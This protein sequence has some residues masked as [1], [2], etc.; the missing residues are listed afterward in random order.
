MKI[1]DYVRVNSP[2]SKNH[3]KDGRVTKYQA[4][5][6][7][8]VKMR[9]NGSY[10]NIKRYHLIQHPLVLWMRKADGA[11]GTMPATNKFISS[12]GGQVVYPANINMFVPFFFKVGE[13]VRLMHNSVG[14]TGDVIEVSIQHSRVRVRFVSRSGGVMDVWRNMKDL[15]LAKDTDIPEKEAKTI[16]LKT[17]KVG[18]D[19][20]S[21][22]TISTETE[23][24][25]LLTIKKKYSQDVKVFDSKESMKEY[26]DKILNPDTVMTL[27]YREITK[28]YGESK[29]IKMK[30][31]TTFEL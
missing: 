2:N 12:L 15:T 25:F 8:T 19:V 17:V 1:G 6:I 30:T 9:H 14:Y 24:E 28:T 27:S 20:K 5:G 11:L 4:C 31:V 7:V 10:I 23:T 26:L 13:R 16:E 21:V 29:S 18:A 22:Q 3:G